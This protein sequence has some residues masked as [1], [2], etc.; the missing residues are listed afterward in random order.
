MFITF[1][2]Y[3]RKALRH[4]LRFRELTRM[5]AYDLQQAKRRWGTNHM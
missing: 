5:E 1:N 4:V 3:K 2:A